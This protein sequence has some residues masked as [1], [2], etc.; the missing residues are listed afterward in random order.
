MTKGIHER[1]IEAELCEIKDLSEGERE[2]I[3][4]ALLA[5]QNAQARY[6]NYWVG[7]AV[8]SE[9]A[10]VFTG[11]NVERCTWTQTT[12]AEQSAIDKMV[13]AEK[14]AKIKRIAIVSGPKDLEIVWPPADVTDEMLEK[15]VVSVPCGHCLQIIW[16]NCHGE[17]NVEILNY[18]PATGAVTKITIDNAFPFRFGPKDLG[19]DYRKPTTNK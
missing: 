2:L 1:F 12:H 14:S 8:E 17:E 4:S 18:N 5:R 9:S 3:H 7:A 19:V 16:E 11:C 15:W 10:W 13:C 6:S